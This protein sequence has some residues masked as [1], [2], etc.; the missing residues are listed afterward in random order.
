MKKSCDLV[1]LALILTLIIGLTAVFLL[2]A[3]LN[4]SILPNQT[5]AP[6][7][8]S[9]QTPDESVPA[10]TAPASPSPTATEQNSVPVYSYIITNTYP[11]DPNAFTEGL[12]MQENGV[13]LESTG[14]NGASSLRRVNLNNG[15]VLQRYDLPEEYFAEGITVVDNKI[16]QLTWKNH[17]GFVYDKNTFELLGNFSVETEGWGLTY[18]GTYLIMSDGSSTLYFLDP[19]T[20]QTVKSINVSDNN[21]SIRNLNELEYV[22]GSIYANIWLT[23]K[24]AVI[25]PTTGQVKAYID[26]TETAQLHTATNIDSVLN[27]IAY[28]PKTNQ[29]YVTGKYWSSLYEIKIII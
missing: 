19:D 22:N 9:K 18:D 17:V 28:N 1:T 27:G 15:V 11:H 2:N 16:V 29:L 6:S 26:L 14:F 21:G 10:S 8:T 20:Y 25:N 5:G 12:V 4:S 24:I 23:S 3:N 13:L 7:T